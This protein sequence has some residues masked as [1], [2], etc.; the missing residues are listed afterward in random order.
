[1]LPSGLLYCRDGMHVEPYNI[2]YA[3]LLIVAL[4]LSCAVPPFLSL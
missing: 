4:I 2:E 1:M 3:L